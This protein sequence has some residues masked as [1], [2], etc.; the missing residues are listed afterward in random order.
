M[1]Q[2]RVTRLLFGSVDGFF[3]IFSLE[4]DMGVATELEVDIVSGDKSCG[5]L[6]IL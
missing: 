4:E 3:T 1:S 2:A 6:F 5:S